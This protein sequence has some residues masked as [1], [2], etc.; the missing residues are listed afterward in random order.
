MAMHKTVVLNAVG[1]T[2]DL[3]SPEHT[4]RLKAFADAGAAV[5]VGPVLP[6]VTTTVQS[7]YLT[8]AWPA[9]HGAVA[10]GWYF[11]DECEVK[12]WRQS[13]KLVQRPKVWE[14]AKGIDP[15]FTCANLF[16]WYA[17]YSTA[18][19]T[20]TPRPM[21]PAT[22]LKLPDVW[23]NPPGLRYDLHRELG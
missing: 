15:S 16:W 8:G 7:T 5:P 4:P 2:P 23:T 11:R 3:L 18:D 1:L 19:Y 21:Y 13:N 10:N 12:F 14:I 17:M 6:A 20:V 9:E 22:G